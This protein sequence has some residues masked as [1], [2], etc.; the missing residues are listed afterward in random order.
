[1]F[2]IV[3]KLYHDGREMHSFVTGV[4]IIYYVYLR[5]KNNFIQ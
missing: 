4:I 5:D 3:I 2:N 1:M